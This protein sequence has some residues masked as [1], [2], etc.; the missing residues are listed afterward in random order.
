M[1]TGGLGVYKAG[2]VLGTVP[3][4]DGGGVGRPVFRDL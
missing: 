2:V 1:L 4:V 3:S